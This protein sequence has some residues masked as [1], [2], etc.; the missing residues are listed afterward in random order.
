MMEGGQEDLTQSEEQIHLWVSRKPHRC[1][2]WLGGNAVCP[3]LPLAFSL[4]H[5]I[6]EMVLSVDKVRFFYTVWSQKQCVREDQSQPA[7]FRTLVLN[8]S[9]TMA[10][11]LIL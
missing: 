6:A 2:G 1:L 7:T 5:V 9:L 10:W 4:I 8:Q 3:D 11:G